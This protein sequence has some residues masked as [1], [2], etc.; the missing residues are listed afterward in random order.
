MSESNI[1]E[2]IIIGA[3]PAGASTAIQLKKMGIEPF[4]IDSRG[5]AGGLIKNAYRVDNYIGTQS[6]S[7]SDISENIKQLERINDIFEQQNA[8]II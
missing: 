8:N 5:Y 7:G 2:I 3:G 1:K 6:I 4:L